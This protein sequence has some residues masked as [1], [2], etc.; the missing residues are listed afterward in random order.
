MP[1]VIDK[2]ERRLLIL[3]SFEKVFSEM[4]YAKGTLKDIAKEANISTS[5]LYAIYK[6][7]EEIF[8]DYFD[9]EIEKTISCINQI[10][11]N[12]KIDNLKSLINL[13]F[14]VI[15]NILENSNERIFFEFF[16]EAYY[17]GR[18]DDFTL[19][20]DKFSNY[21][22]DLRHK[23]LK[24][25]IHSGIPEIDNYEYLEETIGLI[26]MFFK[27]GVIHT[28]SLNKAR[29]TTEFFDDFRR[30]VLTLIDLVTPHFKK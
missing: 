24:T 16:I 7:K 20:M 2:K 6:T 21:F 15:K 19:R 3:N 8:W 5:S 29:Y 17:A 13:I 26:L 30:K 28:F 22:Y 11:E 9:F 14:E 27:E 12:D 4:G 23:L 18:L 10:I 1:K 25:T